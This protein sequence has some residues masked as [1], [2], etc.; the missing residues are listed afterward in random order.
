MSKVLFEMEK[1]EILKGD[2]KIRSR[3]R[4]R[5]LILALILFSVLIHTNLFVSGEIYSI[6]E[7]TT[8]LVAGNATRDGSI[9]LAKNRDLSEYEY[10]WLYR[11]NRQTHKPGEL[12]R[13]QYIQIPEVSETWGWI[14]SKSHTKKWGVGMG[15]NEWGVAVADNDAPTREPLQGERG[16]H[17]NDICRLVLE[18]SR[19]AREGAL[20]AGKLIEEYGHSYIGQIYWIADPEECWIVEGAGRHWAAIRV[21]DGIVVRANQFQITT[22]WDEGSED[23]VDYA[24]NQGWCKSREEFDFARCYS[25]PDYPYSTS[26]TR[27]ERAL[28][29]L[30]GINGTITREDLMRLLG[31][32][33]EGTRMYNTPHNNPNYRTICSKRTVS[34]MVAELRPNIPL[35]MQ[36]MWFCMSTPCTG[37]FIPVYANTSR[38]P[39]PYLTGSG[40]EEI[41]S[42]DEGSAWWVFKKL[43]LLVDDN[44]S[45]LHPKVRS[46]FDAFYNN[47]S[48]QV[49]QLEED[50]INLFLGKR[51]NEA[52]NKIDIFVEEKLNQGYQLCI[53]IVKDLL[54][55]SEEPE[56]KEN[57]EDKIFIYVS[58]LVIAIVIVVSI[59]LLKMISKYY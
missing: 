10:Q 19:S 12:L 13:L 24:I 34:A 49:D 51:D 35:Q 17:D 57:G 47:V 33:Y 21:K 2:H 42:Y 39:E 8:I 15:I 22:Y 32:H 29:L 5:P 28:E 52:Q 7:C 26:Q 16:L 44:Y 54:I 58:I 53:R 50:L 59:Y 6:E 30:R 1:L 27:I 56:K 37:V 23:L 48:K 14:G 36:L 46:S 11:V 38:I 25:P 55:E 3:K 41:S 18:R 45:K 20:L 31:D 9:L 43:Q 40:P 4:V